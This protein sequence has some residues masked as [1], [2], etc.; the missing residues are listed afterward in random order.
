MGKRRRKRYHPIDLK[1][2]KAV[3]DE[4]SRGENQNNED[5]DDY[6]EDFIEIKWRIK[7]LNYKNRPPFEAIAIELDEDEKGYDMVAVK[8]DNDID[9]IT[10]DRDTVVLLEDLID[11]S[12]Q[13]SKEF[14]EIKDF[15]EKKIWNQ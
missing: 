15:L 2:D 3:H 10:L 9:E 5:N 13:G 4:K 1:D 6:S 14:K 7:L 12:S 11:D 8:I